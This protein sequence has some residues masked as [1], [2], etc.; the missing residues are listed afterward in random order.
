MSIRQNP[1]PGAHLICFRGDTLR[2]T[3]EL[4]Q[5]THGRAWLRTNVGHG[6][7]IRDEIVRAVDKELPPL[8]QAWFD[9]PMRTVRPGRFEVTLALT[10]VGHFEAKCFFLP[11]RSRDPI[12]PA[13]DN[14]VLNVEPA[15]T[16]C[17]NLLYNA[18]VRQFGPNKAGGAKRPIAD[19]ELAVLDAAGYTVIPPSGTFRDL[20]GELDF[21]FG[22]LGCRYLQLLPIHP[23]PT[24]YARMGRFGSPYAA[25]SFTAV[26]PALARFDPL[27]TPLEQFV[28]LVDAV[29]QRHGKLLLDIAINHTG[30]AADIH[31]TH[32]EWLSRDPDGRIHVP[33]A[34][35]IKWE[36]L[37]KLDYANKALWQYMADVFLT[38]CR[39]GVDG[40]RCDAGYMI[41]MEAWRY[42]IAVVR[43]QYPD[44]LFLL[45]GLGGKMTVTR[46]LLN[47]GNFNWAYSELFQNYTRDEIANY[48]PQATAVSER[49]GIM[50]HF[51]ETHD[52]PRLA[53][54]SVRHARM[55]TA[56]CA[57]CAPFGA[58]G[59]AAG[60]EWFAT[61]KINVHASPGL[62][63]G[64]ADN[65]VAQISRLA[66]LLK[67]H[68][69][70]H[71]QTNLSLVQTGPG[72][73]VA[74][75]RHHLPTGLR[76]L[77]LAN[78]DEAAGGCAAWDGRAFDPGDGPLHD[79]L[80]GRS[81][82]WEMSGGM[83]A[84]RLSP[85]EV[86]CLARSGGTETSCDEAAGY[87]PGVVPRIARQQLQAKVLSLSVA[88]TGN[89]AV[90]G[91]DAEA[92]ARMLHQDPLAFCR[93]GP[94]A[95]AVPR[96]V[97]WCWP[98]DVRR[99]VMVPPAHMLLVTAAHAFHLRLME[100]KRTL[101]REESLPCADG[102]WFVL[103]PPGPS[104]ADMTC[105]R[106]KLSVFLPDG[107]RH[108]TA[109]LL[110]LA[111]PDRLRIPPV[112]GRRD[113]VAAPRMFLDTN[114]RGGM[115]RAPVIWGALQS[116][117]D[118]LLAANLHPDWP[119]DRNIL[120]ARCRA[121]VVYQGYSQ[122]LSFDCFRAFHVD[123]QDRGVWRFHVPTGQGEHVRLTVQMDMVEDENTI[124]LLFY[125]HPAKERQGRLADGRPV[126][127]I[128]RP[129]VENRDFH[130]TTKAYLGPETAW[131]HAVAARP[132]GF[133]FQ[134]EASARLEM[135]L[136]GGRFHPDPEWQY[137][138]HRPLEAER[139]FDAEGDLFS[140]G[141]F[142]VA[143]SGDV[144]ALLVAHA[145][146]NKAA[147][148]PA[149]ATPASIDAALY[150][151]PAAM[152]IGAALTRALGHFVVRRGTRKT[153]VAGYPW[154]LDWGRD[155]LIVVRGL[156]AA[157]RIA[158]ARAVLRQF[159][160][161]EEQ[162]TLPNMIAGA[163][164][165][166]RDTSDAPLWFFAGCGEVT[167]AEK[168]L[169]FLDTM[170]GGRSV[171]EILFSIA[172]AYQTGTSG[173]VRMDPETGLVFSP[174]HFT[175]M[176]TNFPAATPR[177]GYPI[178]IQALWH[179]ALVFL[180]R[181]DP[182]GIR[183]DWPAL[184][185]R[186]AAA[187][188][189]LYARDGQGYLADCL[190]ASAGTGASKAMPDDHLRP[191]QLLAIT[192]GALKDVSVSRGVLDA[193]A[194]LLVPGAIRSLADRPVAHPLAV[195]L[196]DRALN[197]PRA[198]YWG[199]YVGD[200][201]TQRKPAYHNG[202][203]WP[204]MMPSFCEAWAMVY[205][206]EGV[207]AARAWLGSVARLLSEGCV[208]QVPEVLDGDVPHR[209]RGCDAQ[210]WSVSE[211]LRVWRK[212]TQ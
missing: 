59:F 137:M 56:L 20:V 167:A 103:L 166:N 160:Q 188:S 37:T 63:W 94:L 70:F 44:T 85:G 7:D 193:C 51:A 108:E 198:P 104:Q 157:D 92:A 209:Q 61:E 19:Q 18:F 107:C 117:Y 178:E 21:I 184:A 106:L 41:P 118:A 47:D 211:F 176:D 134:P 2:F 24:T 17:A 28:E 34:W 100:G 147:S 101:A 122:A 88:K 172:D 139:G 5:D 78:L 69:A 156:C 86:L 121:W 175:W 177:E 159:G 32:P 93:Q 91:L 148:A 83:P 96:V 144:P 183:G 210:A 145:V 189:D 82:S 206:P 48:L 95:D 60:V 105:R 123:T 162:G 155:S 149:V 150:E 30:W 196:D 124:R 53:A 112:F 62:N 180:G 163:A 200:E 81:V 208:G 179:H 185:R 68:P 212:L 136:V 114:R 14:T 152:G 39:R 187:I 125:R 73:H 170:A 67:T 129:D 173:G 146:S 8:G 199:R 16:C 143:L 3:L 98:A 201:D 197:D 102:S 87:P 195:A 23:T 79:L 119:E 151:E 22:T 42:I 71:D 142:T 154:F 135:T 15:H 1:D 186:V 140:P 169:R 192:L 76:L 97:T 36:D 99:E 31:E 128:V 168:S 161:F 120:L 12:W 126:R 164:A 202:T 158:D 64:A 113:L 153:V 6:A 181:I 65:Q 133:V 58:F 50:V 90:D 27:A 109:R 207:P 55:R 127:L 131:R 132:D 54:R 10:E 33:G 110:Q 26:D 57:L 74:L 204:W 190:H 171:R 66:V 45:E 174:A 49:D 203:A 35:G 46:A 43:G 138:V 40:F 11:H 38:W 182:G 4:P 89:V 130:A 165:A 115:L 141:Y 52:N 191:N 13:G 75:C 72:N 111:D 29:H 84:C 9:V 77:V 116:R 80:T 194:A 205:G 25:L